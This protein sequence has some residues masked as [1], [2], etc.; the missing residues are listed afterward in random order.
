MSITLSHSSALTVV[1]MLRAEGLNL[2]EMD[3]TALARPSTWVGKRWTMREF[4]PSIWRWPQPAKE[5]H[6]HVLVPKGSPYVRMATVETHVLW[7]GGTSSEALWVDEHASIV[8][9]E[10]LYLEMA[11]TLPLPALVM[12]GYELCGSFSRD[13]LNPIDG[14]AKIGVP[15]ATSVEELSSY[16][17]ERAGVRGIAMARKALEYIC[18]DALSPMEALLGMVYSL[19]P[20]ES[21]Y[22]MGPLTLNERVRVG[23][24]DDTGHSRSRYP[25]ISFS[26]APLGLNYDGEDHLDLVGLV[27]A[28]RKETS[29]EGEERAAAEAALNEKIDAV[30][31][32][33]VDDNARNRQLAASGRIVFPIVK[34]DVYGWNCLD[35]F[36]RQVLRCA[37]SV[38]GIDV[39][40]FEQT[41]DDTERKRD[42]YALITSFMPS[43]GPLRSI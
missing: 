30:R 34:E 6:L 36:T 23:D 32:K 11:E 20:E 22:G 18:N 2:R 28:A 24:P 14:E 27:Q 1:R 42:R 5:S 16:V 8:R 7:R 29:V 9:P 3:S 43:R 33:V 21:G 4:D 39:S 31:S 25:D 35:E 38:F 10:L 12:L 41:L 40:R 19:P 15:R 13:P 26:F 17:S 37:Q